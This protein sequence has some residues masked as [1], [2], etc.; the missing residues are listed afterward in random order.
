VKLIQ[1]VRRRIAE[2]PCSGGGLIEQ[3][4]LRS[5]A[6][7]VYGALA[8]LADRR[9]IRTVGKGP[10]EL[11]WGEPGAPSSAARPP[12]PP[13][14]FRMEDE[15]LAHIENAVWRMTEGLSGHIF[16]ELRRAA[17][18]RADR[19]AYDG[20][21]PRKAADRALAELGPPVSARRF[22]QLVDQGKN[23]PLR[24]STR[25]ARNFLV[26]VALVVA[27]FA[28][29]R[30]LVVGWYRLPE[31]QVS[32]A[33]TLVPGVEG[34]DELVLANLLAYR[35]GSPERGDIAVFEV[36]GQPV[37]YIKRVMGL[38][39]E[40]IEIRQGDIWIDGERLVKE[41]AFLERLLVPLFGMEGFEANEAGYRQKIV[42]HTGFPLP[43]GSVEKRDVPAGDVVLEGS[44]Q[45]EGLKDSVTILMRVGKTVRHQVV[46][47][48]VGF[49]AGVFVENGTI[50]RGQPCQLEPGRRYR[51][52][53]TNADRSFRFHLDGTK[54]ARATIKAEP[55][56]LRFEILGKGASDLR[57][58]RDVVYTGRPGAPDRWTLGENAYFL[59]G[60]NSPVSQDSRV[61]GAVSRKSLLG[62]AWRVI[63]PL[64]RARVI[65]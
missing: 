35:L 64:E 31:G 44:V 32:M 20:T 23:P 50:V 60:D 40:R 7:L 9:E 14:T 30:W 24:L 1:E 21:A 34:G 10:G 36:A 42:A 46:L 18:A 58:S 17:V 38:P 47:N 37:P 13:P 63:W 62:R 8:R 16:E 5:N 48:A 41:K 54:V 2:S 22:L 52:W 33:P 11:I 29:L 28:A 59:L 55:G 56:D 61:F 51:F 57:L 65:R 49:G 25:R 53:L 4:P 15:D 3:I 19:L 45:L 43:D 39:R 6:V 12:G 26:G 27:L